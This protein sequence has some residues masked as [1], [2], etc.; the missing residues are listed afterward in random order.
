MTD[1]E[2]SPA[3]RIANELDYLG[4][5][6]RCPDFPDCREERLVRDYLASIQAGEP[7]GRW[8]SGCAACDQLAAGG[9][10]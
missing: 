10:R 9:S 6:R 4:D 3:D 7:V 1:F 2:L 8:V 5:V